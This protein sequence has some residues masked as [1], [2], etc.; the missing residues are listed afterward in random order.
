MASS[1]SAPGPV[2]DPPPTIDW[3]PG[4]DLNDQRGGRLGMTVLPGK[5]GAS[6]R[7]P[8]RVYR[9]DLAVDLQGLVD[10]GVGRLLLLVEDAELGRWGHPDL[11]ARAAT[12]GIIVDRHPMPDGDPPASLEAMDA[13]LH[14]ISE[15]RESANVAVACMGG[16]GR[17]G[18][19]V[20]CVLVAAGWDPDDAIARVREV[21]H[22]QA[23]ETADQE[24]F[25]RGWA[26]ARA[27]ESTRV[28]E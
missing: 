19:I 24:A 14:S 26:D 25:V 2:H 11:A 4:S 8:G 16:V 9:N 1:I 21:R 23:V 13:I 12:I 7:Y 27:A 18:T 15:A 20:A 10:A 17:T 5:H 6:T 28:P 3:L 22:P